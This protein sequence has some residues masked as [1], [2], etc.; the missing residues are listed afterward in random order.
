MKPLYIDARENSIDTIV[1]YCNDLCANDEMK[2]C[3]FGEK[4]DLTLHI[5]KDEDFGTFFWNPAAYNMVTISTFR[6]GKLVDETGDIEV[7][8][9]Y[10]A[11]EDI[12]SYKDFAIETY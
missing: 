9:L 4:K 2:V 7:R 11:L 10:A 1:D 5:C 3:N 6:N 12:N 8:D